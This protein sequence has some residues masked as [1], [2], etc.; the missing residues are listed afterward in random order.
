M[1]TIN[2]PSLAVSNIS[3]HHLRGCMIL[4]R[5]NACKMYD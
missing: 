2:N 4:A 5:I 1:Y 3:L